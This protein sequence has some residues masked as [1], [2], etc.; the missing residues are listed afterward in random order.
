MRGPNR[1]CVI[2]A[3][4]NL[5]EWDPIHTNTTSTNG[6][7]TFADPASANST[8]ILSRR[9]HALIPRSQSPRRGAAVEERSQLHGINRNQQKRSAK[10]AHENGLG[11]P[12]AILFR[13]TQ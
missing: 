2:E 11:N 9:L 4:T 5:I 13:A 8:A 3:T 12:L 7:F 1:V 6:T 10:I